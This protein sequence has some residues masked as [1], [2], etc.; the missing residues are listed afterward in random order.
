MASDR[1]EVYGRWSDLARRALLAAPEKAGTVDE[2][3]RIAMAKKLGHGKPKA[4]L[5]RKLTSAL[6]TMSRTKRP[7]VRLET[8]RGGRSRFVLIEQQQLLNAPK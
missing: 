5:K 2:L 8:I 7:S 3:V 1:S 4:F 6:H